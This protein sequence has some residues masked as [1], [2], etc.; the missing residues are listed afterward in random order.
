MVLN[1]TAFP[2]GIKAQVYDYFLESWKPLEKTRESY[3]KIETFD[4]A[5]DQTTNVIG[6]GDLVEKP[7]GVGFTQVSMSEGW[8]VYGSVKTYGKKIAITREVKEDHL[9]LKNFL[10][11]LM[12]SWTEDYNRTLEKFC[13]QT[14]NKGGFT[15][16]HSHF[17]ASI[18]GFTDPTGD[19]IFDS[20]PLFNLV[21]NERTS[22]GGGTYFNGLALAFSRDN[23]KTAYRRFVDTINR[24]ERDEQMD[25]RPKIILAHPNLQFD[26][27]E[28]LN[29]PENPSTA[30]RSTNVTYRL[31]K[32][33]YCPYLTNTSQWTLMD[34]KKDLVLLMRRLPEFGFWY[35][36]D[37][38]VYYMKISARYGLR[39]DNWRREVSCNFSTS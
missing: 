6:S 18:P 10:K 25:N 31:L 11:E 30:N 27:D 39:V 5:Y 20:K 7:E 21:G 29:S 4:K 38:E 2:E 23:L 1:R 16:G 15:S 14:I 3:M 13:A 17:N 37:A 9:R 33:V 12:P 28:V 35:D 36:D 22:K 8:N 26:I 34:P 19:Y 32:A 24:D